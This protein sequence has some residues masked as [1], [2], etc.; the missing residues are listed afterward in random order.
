MT[1]SSPKQY[2]VRFKGEELRRFDNWNDAWAY[3]MVVLQAYM[4][5]IMTPPAP[6]LPEVVPLHLAGG[7][8]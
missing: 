7:D 5:E 1:D 4:V 8:A 6:A 2:A 3:R